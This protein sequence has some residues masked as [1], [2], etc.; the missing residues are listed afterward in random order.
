LLLW[1]GQRSGA[2]LGDGAAFH[3]QSNTW[4][5]IGSS[6]APVARADHAALWSGTEMLVVD[7][8]DASG[9]LSS[10]AAYDPL[11]DQWRALSNL[12]PPLARKQTVAAW[13]GVE[14]MVFGGLVNGQRVASLQRLVP[15]PAWYL[16]R[17]L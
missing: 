8:A 7:G 9:A 10:G 15:Q 3:P 13:T 5:P 16:Y 2:A 17:K 6:N 11:A 1:G 12:G 4:T 14:L